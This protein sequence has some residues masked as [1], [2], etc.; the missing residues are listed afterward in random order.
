MRFYWLQLTCVLTA[1]LC[2]YWCRK[3]FVD[4][5]EVLDVLVGY[6]FCINICAL[7]SFTA[8]IF[9]LARTFLD[10]CNDING[11]LRLM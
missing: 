3:I 7:L 1:V 6:I 5:D 11:Y 2:I 10:L 8:Q 9:C 4:S